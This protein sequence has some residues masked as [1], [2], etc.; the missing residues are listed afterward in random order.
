MIPL[1]PL[2]DAVADLKVRQMPPYVR[3]AVLEQAEA[4]RAFH[5][6]RSPETADA[7]E[8]ALSDMARASKI[9]A[10]VPHRHD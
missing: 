7:R 3:E 6:C 8:Y 2:P 5:L 9:L 10:A 1:S 4:E